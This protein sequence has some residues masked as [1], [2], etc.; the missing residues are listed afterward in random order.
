MRRQLSLTRFILSSIRNEHWIY[1]KWCCQ[2]IFLMM[3][4]HIC[5]GNVKEKKQSRLAILCKYTC[6][7]EMPC[8]DIS[9]GFNCP[10]L[11]SFNM[12]FFR[13]FFSSAILHTENVSLHLAWAARSLHACLFYTKRETKGCNP[14]HLNTSQTYG[15]PQAFVLLFYAPT[16]FFIPFFFSTADACMGFV[17]RPALGLLGYEMKMI[18]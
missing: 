7:N 14:M 15:E 18:N 12:F 10:M 11:I 2:G 16:I 8:K 5:T 1:T 3:Q 9:H 6:F 4:Q 13:F 17:L